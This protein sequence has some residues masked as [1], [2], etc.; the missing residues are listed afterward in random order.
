MLQRLERCGNEV[1]AKLTVDVTGTIITL[2]AFGTVVGQ[3]AEEDFPTVR[4][5][6]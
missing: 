1:A 2:Q 5:D 3:I 6:V 4:K